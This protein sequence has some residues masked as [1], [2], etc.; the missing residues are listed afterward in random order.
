MTTVIDKTLLKQ[1]LRELIHE[2][3]VTFKNILK[4]ILKESSEITEDEQFDVLINKNFQ[5]FGETFRALA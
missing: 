1:A 2:E 3:P 5:R 4:D